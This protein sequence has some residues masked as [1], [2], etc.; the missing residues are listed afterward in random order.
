MV[1]TGCYIL[2]SH[3]LH[4]CCLFCQWGLVCGRSSYPNLSQ[5][6]FFLGLMIGAWVFGNL[7]DIYGRKAVTFL[8]L[9]GCVL[10]GFGYSLAN[11]F[12]LFAVFRVL[13]GFTKQA[14]II[15][16]F[17]LIVE[18]VGASKRTYVTIVNQLIFTIGIVTLPLL[19]YCIRDW[20]TLSIII[21]L[22]GVGFLSM[23]RY[24]RGPH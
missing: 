6:G 21:S 15:A 22:L 18:I 14:L 23:W 8:G 12:F 17:T 24:V 13:V 4:Y 5:S 1:L 7:S 3:T 2:N 16:S 20:R 11:S 9:L 19:A 10:V